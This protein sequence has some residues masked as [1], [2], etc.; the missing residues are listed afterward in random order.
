MADSVSI[1]FFDEQFR[2]QSKGVALTLNS[3]EELALPYLKGEVLDF[4]CGMGNLS[5][6]AACQG[7]KVTALD[8]SPAAIEHI[9]SRAS[10]TGLP[11][12]ATLADLRDYPLEDHYDAVVSIGL[13]M[14]FNCAR[15]MEILGDLKAHVR[16]GGIAAVN[17]LVEGT[18]YM[19]MFNPADHCLF[20]PMA[21]RDEFE[22]WTIERIEFS[23]FAAPGDTV[24]RFCTVVAR[25]D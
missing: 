14:F 20:A 4:G 15:A 24:K 11:V 16:P 10:A 23:E 25:K 9:R 19:G 7:C 12:S 22:N 21:L 17:V 2:E 18:T 13:L 5:F 6:A 1:A 8:A 3:F